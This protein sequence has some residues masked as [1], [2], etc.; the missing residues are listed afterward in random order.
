DHGDPRV[1]PDDLAVPEVVVVG[2]GPGGLAA[3]VTCARAGLEVLVL[4]AEP[5][6]GGGLRTRGAGGLAHDVCSAV[7]PLALASPFFRSLGL[8]VELRVPE[9]SYAHPLDG[10]EAVVAWRDLDRMTDELGTSRWAETFA[11]LVERA[12]DVVALALGDHRSWPRGAADDGAAGLLGEA[13]A[14]GRSR[15]PVSRSP[16]GSRARSVRSRGG[17]VRT[18]CSPA[19]RRTRRAD[20]QPSPGTRGP[21]CSGRSRTRAAG[22]SRS[23]DRRRSRTRSSPSSRRLAGGSRPT[24]PCAR[25]PTCRPPGP[26]CGTPRP[27]PSRRCTGHDSAPGGRPSGGPHGAGSGRR[28]SSSS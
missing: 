17:H 1:R 12:D 23:G 9:A 11:P 24:G 14:P 18:R 28:P 20:R 16:E 27:R 3:A 6:L 4:E 13:L 2:S 7:H 10:G 26:C 5:D 25:A 19:S 15:A 22:R 21:C 8:D